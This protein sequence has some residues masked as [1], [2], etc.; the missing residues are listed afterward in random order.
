MWWVVNATP[1]PLQPLER[2]GIVYIEGWVDRVPVWTIAENF[3]SP[4]V[5]RIPDLPGHN[6]SLYRLRYAK[7]KKNQELSF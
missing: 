3:A 2:P 4:K 1:W 5:F 7:T 6:E